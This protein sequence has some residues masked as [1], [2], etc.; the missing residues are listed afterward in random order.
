VFDTITRKTFKTVPVVVPPASE[1]R[2]FEGILS[3]LLERIL[4]NGQE[5]QTISELR[6][7][8]LPKLISGELRVPVED[9][10]AEPPPARGA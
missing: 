8:L 3:P 6:D 5:S 4:I 7:T 1:A 10:D 2:R 9:A